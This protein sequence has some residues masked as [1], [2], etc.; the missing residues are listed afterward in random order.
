MLHNSHRKRL[1]MI[2][3]LS[4]CFLQAL[5]NLISHSNQ[6]ITITSRVLAF[7]LKGLKGFFS[8]ISRYNE[9]KS[10]R[11]DWSVKQET[12][13]S[14]LVAEVWEL[15]Y[16]LLNNMLKFFNIF[17]RWVIQR[18]H[19]H[20]DA[21]RREQVR[22]GRARAAGGGEGRHIRLL[23]ARAASAPHALPVRPHHWQLRQ[24]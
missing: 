2:S 9:E 4:F 22:R 12:L 16:L 5:F 1:D 7:R 23:P 3:F 21:G 11:S 10:H 17:S 13:G 19:Q 6:I 15:L 14:Y 20:G 18:L 24:V 8:I